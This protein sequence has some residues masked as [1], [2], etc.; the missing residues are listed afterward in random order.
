MAVATGG[1]VLRAKK[2]LARTAGAGAGWEERGCVNAGAA[3]S[4]VRRVLAPSAAHPLARAF[5]QRVA[6]A[7]WY[8]GARRDPSARRPLGAAGF[9]PLPVDGAPAG[10][11]ARAPLP[12]K[13]TRVPFCSFVYRYSNSTICLIAQSSRARTFYQ[14]PAAAGPDLSTALDQGPDKKEPVTRRRR[15]RAPASAACAR[16]TP[17]APRRGSRRRRAPRWSP[18]PCCARPRSVGRP[19]RG[20][21]VVCL[22][23]EGLGRVWGGEGIRH[24]SA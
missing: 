20:G 16:A 24:A 1:F 14:I 12:S 10:G 6:Y 4:R 17:A 18:G 2:R 11:G 22:G 13:I 8:R 19:P 21:V 7:A 9:R 5:E 15:G 3:T 23:G